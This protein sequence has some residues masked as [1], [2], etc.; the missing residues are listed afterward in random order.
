VILTP[1]HSSKTEG[2]AFSMLPDVS[3]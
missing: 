2:A 1:C 3:G